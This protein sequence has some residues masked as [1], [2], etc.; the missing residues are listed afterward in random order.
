MS[1]TELVRNN[2]EGT[3][4]NIVSSPLAFS[5]ASLSTADVV[6]EE[7]GPRWHGVL[8]IEGHPTSDKRMLILGEVGER[9]LPRPLNVQ[10]ATAEGH[11][12]S[13]NAGRIEGIQHIP[14]S[15]VSEDIRKEFGLEDLPEQAVVIWGEG[16]FDRSEAADEAQRMLANGAGISLDMTRDRTAL[17]DPETLEEIDGEL[18]LE[19]IL[20][21]GYIEAFG[22]KIGGATIVTLE[23]FEQASIR[24]V[25]DGV[26]VASAHGIHSLDATIMVAS[27]GPLRPPAE[28]F[29]DPKFTELTPLTIT[30]EGR[31]YGHL[32]DWDGCHVGFS[33]VCTPPFR[34]PSNYAVFNASCGAGIETAEGEII[35]C[36]KIM[37]SRTG[38]GHAPTDA[39]IGYQEIQ[40]YY[41]NATKVGAF[42][43]AGADRFGTWLAGALRSDLNDLDIQHLRTHPPSGDWRPVKGLT[44][45]IAAFSVPVGGFPI[46]RRALVASA[47]GEINAI[48]TAPLRIED[49]P[50]ARYR[51]RVMLSQRLREIFSEQV[52]DLDHKVFYEG[53]GELKDYPSATRKR[54]A[55]AGTAMPDGSYPI[56]DCE[57]V[58]NA[59]QAIGRS[60]PARRS[61]V[62]AH[63]NKRAR[64]LGCK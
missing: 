26:L 60:D 57:D 50:H 30:K 33:G 1:L 62:R 21:G 28:W 51:R 34:S 55:K 20:F 2:L 12:G 6:E 18:G 42:V 53:E 22:G 49:R 8:G 17:Y 35:P 23:A 39:R 27:A 58:Q 54:M 36:G 19:E 24:V 11:A 15:D 7:R 38:S 41:D 47:D 46:V 9:D 40:R 31:V 25:D 14:L 5:V 13:A 64:A 43:R 3:A 59:R 37:F 29:E 10:L 16:T 48:I 52:D 45:L 61:A 32:C 63:I 44:D 4:S 56:A